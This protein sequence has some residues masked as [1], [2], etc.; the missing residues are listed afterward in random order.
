MPL[1]VSSCR[2]CRTI[3]LG[4]ILQ[5]GFSRHKELPTHHFYILYIHG[6]VVIFSPCGCPEFI[7]RR[8]HTFSRCFT[9]GCRAQVSSLYTESVMNRV[10]AMLGLAGEA[11]SGP[12]C[13]LMSPK[14]RVARRRRTGA[15]RGQNSL[16]KNVLLR[17]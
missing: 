17:L 2:A 8:Q 15:Y 10:A 4:Y 1:A 16:F 14:R 5:L 6:P 7:S 11:R 3:Y 9:R 13:V 12:F